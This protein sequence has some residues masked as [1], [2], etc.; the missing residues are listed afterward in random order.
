MKIQSW[1]QLASLY[2]VQ[3]LVS[4]KGEN[5]PKYFSSTVVK[6]IIL[7]FFI[8]KAIF[9]MLFLFYLKT[10]QRYKAIVKYYALFKVFGSVWN[11]C[12]WC[13]F[14]HWKFWEKII[15]GWLGCFPCS[16]FLNNPRNKESCVYTYTSVNHDM[17]GWRFW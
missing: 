4:V 14:F 6:W 3:Q 10:A 16:H 13:I 2:Y 7:I 9:K 11:W 17:I 1:N 12:V 5:H 8:W 15:L